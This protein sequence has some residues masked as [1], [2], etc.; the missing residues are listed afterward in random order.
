M[1]IL[2]TGG[3]GFTGSNVVKELA[4]RGNEVISL[5]IVPPDDLVKRYVEPWK[6]SVTFLKG[7]IA[8]KETVEEVSAYFKIDRIVHTATYTGYGDQEKTYGS[9][10]CEVN[11]QGTVNMLDLARR[12]DAKQFLYVSSAA[13]YFGGTPIETPIR[14]DVVLHTA[15]YPSSEPYGFYGITKLGSELI[16]ERYG[17]L[18][19]FE[20]ASIRMVQNFGPI[21]RI[22][23]Y[24]SR[25]SMPGQW[26]GWAA[27][28]EPIEAAPFGKG[29]TEGRSVGIDHIYVRD[30][31]AAIAAMLEAPKL[32]HNEYNISRSES[33]FLDDLVAAMRKAAPGA[34]FVEPIPKDDEVKRPGF[35]FDN[36]RMKEDF[37]FVPKYDMASALEDFM[38]WRRDFN[39]TD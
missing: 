26:T 32:P 1:A 16:T 33:V 3:T 7:D 6:K 10:I 5:D 22:T 8:S 13:V 34:K 29:I 11:F 38:K 28:G 9:R 12:L 2:V 20:T 21:E 18:Y 23:P 19:G 35:L 4:E 14:E 31:A 27:R 30:T 37:G 39:F 17:H 25:I 36:T 24:H 15:G